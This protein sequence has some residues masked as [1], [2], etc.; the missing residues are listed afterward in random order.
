MKLII[1]S[2]ASV[3]GI[4]LLSHVFP[5]MQTSTFTVENEHIHTSWLVFAGLAGLFY[6]VL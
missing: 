1:V 2:L 6:K 3:A 4:M 5:G